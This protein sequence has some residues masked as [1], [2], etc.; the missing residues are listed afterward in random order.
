MT[1][2]H[3]AHLLATASVPPSRPC[4][5]SARRWPGGGAN[6]EEAE[7]ISATCSPWAGVACGSGSAARSERR[8]R[9]AAVAQLVVVVEQGRVVGT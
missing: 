9:L 6:G 4:R 7:G 2:L 1:P 3:L 8:W 5:P